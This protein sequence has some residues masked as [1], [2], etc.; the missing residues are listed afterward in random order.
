M[1]RALNSTLTTFVR[2]GP[3]FRLVCCVRLLLFLT[4]SPRACVYLD[5]LGQGTRAIMDIN[6]ARRLLAAGLD[7]DADNRRRAE[8]ELKQVRLQTTILCLET[9]RR[10]VAGSAGFGRAA[11]WT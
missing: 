3:V 9:P 11:S 10:L 2:F 4:I 8:L 5:T 7:P 1:R 6:T